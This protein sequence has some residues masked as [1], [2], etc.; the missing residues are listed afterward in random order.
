MTFKIQRMLNPLEESLICAKSTR[1]SEIKTNVSES[2]DG[3]K[4]ESFRDKNRLGAHQNQQ[5]TNN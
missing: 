2:L 1:I 5:S 4:V 3:L